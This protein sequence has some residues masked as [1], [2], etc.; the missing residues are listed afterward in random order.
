MRFALCCD[1]EGCRHRV[2]PPS[3]RFLGRR[4]FVAPVVVL[5]SAM[6]H[7]VTPSRAAALQVAFGVSEATL[8]R[9]RRWW[10]EQ[11]AQGPVWKAL[12]GLLRV[13]VDEARLPASWMEVY[14]TG[15]EQARVCRVLLDL[16]PAEAGC[17]RER[18][19]FLK[20]A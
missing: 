15:S 2:L 7:G 11:F 16:L 19:C 17:T 1:R 13:P 9:W 4:V 8:A 14:G 18:A 6:R 5:V 12:R 3:V 10:L 20:V